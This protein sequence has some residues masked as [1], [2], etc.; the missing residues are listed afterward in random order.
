MNLT[1]FI[2]LVLML[3]VLAACGQSPQTASPPIQEEE[4]DDDPEDPKPPEPET[5]V[6]QDSQMLINTLVEQDQS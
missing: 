5:E 6:D 3:S 4:N 2:A 1:R